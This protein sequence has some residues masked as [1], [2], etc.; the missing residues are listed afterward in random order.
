MPRPHLILAALVA[1]LATLPALLAVP[2]HAAGSVSVGN[3]SNGA[4]IDSRY[5]STLT[6]QGRGFQSIKGGHG[7]IYVWFGTVKGAWQPS[8]GGASGSNYLYVP[9]SE[10]KGNKGFQR[11]VAFPG[12]DTASSANGG[13]LSA[14]GSWRVNLLV[15]GPTFQAVGRNGAV[16]TVDCRKVT[17]GVITVGAHGVH[18][19]NNETFTPVSV[20][21]LQQQ[22]SSG[23][24]T[25]PGQD[26][27][28]TAPQAVEQQP[29]APVRTGKP[30]LSVDRASA[31][32][33]RGLSFVAKNF[34]PGSQLTVILD[35]GLVASG[36]HQIGTDGTVAGVLQLP[37]GLRGGTHELRTFGSGREA[38]V[39]FGVIAGEADEAT[40]TAPASAD[41]EFSAPAVAFV[42]VAACVF[43]LALVVTARRLL[44]G[45]RG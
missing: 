23:Q 19:A 24:T 27:T 13:T 21:D 25:T 30:K 39:K 37:E 44:G 9:D 31:V 45:R 16:E 7:G 4:V 10:T 38:A 17:C 5:S 43:L 32:A 6:V 22:P 15:P 12:S 42:S 20:K 3:G 41:R 29:V 28:T 2:A 18:N 34:T 1:G 36:P 8:R 35:D 14:D 33:G 40:D 26:G 11:Y